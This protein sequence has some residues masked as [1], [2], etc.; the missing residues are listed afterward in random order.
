MTRSVVAVT[1]LWFESL[2]LCGLL[3]RHCTSLLLGA[4]EKDSLHALCR[5]LVRFTRLEKLAQVFVDEGGIPMLFRVRRR[6]NFKNFYTMATHIIRHIF[7]VGE[8]KKYVYESVLR[9]IVTSPNVINLKEVKPSGKNASEFHYLMKKMAAI[10][11]RDHECFLE[12][13]SAIYRFSVPFEKENYSSHKEINPLYVSVTEKRIVEAPS[14][15]SEAQRQI[16]ELMTDNIVRRDL[17]RIGLDGENPKDLTEEEQKGARRIRI[18]SGWPPPEKKMDTVEVGQKAKEGATD[19]EGDG[20][21][22]KEGDG[23]GDKEGDGKGDKGKQAKGDTK[24]KD[25]SDS[26]DD[27]PRR[28][29]KQEEIDEKNDAPEPWRK[30]ELPLLTKSALTRL[31]MELVQ[32]Y[33]PVV[34]YIITCK[35]TVKLEKKN[36]SEVCSNMS[37]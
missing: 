9:N 23:K 13:L 27:T 22:D 8:M 25:S 37:T 33:P 21:G 14:E 26:D 20:K 31:L 7:E 24:D 29:R 19:K 2:V 36:P 32:S 35:K 15:L 3:I 12:T 11:M 5:L 17:P 34:R 28:D 18:V 30:Y 16:V 4:L 1:K 10:S 6:S